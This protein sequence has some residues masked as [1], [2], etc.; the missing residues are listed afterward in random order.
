MA[1]RQ[2]LALLVALYERAPQPSWINVSQCL[3]FLDRPADVAA[4]LHRLLRGSQVAACPPPTARQNFGRQNFVTLSGPACAL[5]CTVVFEA[6]R[7]PPR[8]HYGTS[9]D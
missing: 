7:Q 5:A 4:V 3:M 6:G 2:V 9:G 8:Q 1:G